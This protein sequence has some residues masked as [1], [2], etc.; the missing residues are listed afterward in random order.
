[1]SVA[2]DSRLTNWP[3]RSFWRAFWGR[4]WVGF[5]ITFVIF[6]AWLAMMPAGQRDRILNFWASVR[7]PALSFHPEVLL[8]APRSVQIHA[9]GALM[10]LVVGAGIF[11]LPKGTG[12]HRLLGWSWVGSMIVVAATS[13]AMIADFRNGG[14]NPLHAFTAI[15][16]VSLWAGLTGIRRGNVARHAGSM[17]GLYVGGLLIAGLFAFIPGRTMWVVMFG[18]G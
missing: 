2:P 9:A 18:G 10:A 1:M 5:L 3:D 15:T 8:T 4:I 11:L 7:M 14:I 12:F 16:V 17:T 13:V 6:G